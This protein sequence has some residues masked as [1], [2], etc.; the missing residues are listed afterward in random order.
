MIDAGIVA[1]YQSHRVTN[2]I[3][4]LRVSRYPQSASS[5]AKQTYDFRDVL[6]TN[7]SHYIA[8]TKF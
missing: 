4:W 7:K 2:V 5:L 8:N 3:H 1:K 6:T